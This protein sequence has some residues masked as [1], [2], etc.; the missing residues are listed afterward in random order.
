MIL[1]NTLITF[2]SKFLSDICLQ[3]SREDGPACLAA[4]GHNYDRAARYY[5]VE[6]GSIHRTPADASP[7]VVDCRRD[8]FGSLSHF[9]GE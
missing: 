3:E 1:G 9:Q 8:P 6:P 4:L 2:W 5:E 7:M